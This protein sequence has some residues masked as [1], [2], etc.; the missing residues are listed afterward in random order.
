MAQKVTGI[1]FLYKMTLSEGLI[2]SLDLPGMFGAREAAPSK[3]STNG[4]IE[5]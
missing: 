3:N 1:Q 4:E 2:K 5:Y